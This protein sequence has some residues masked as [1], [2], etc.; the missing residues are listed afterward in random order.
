MPWR[1]EGKRILI[2]G[3]SAGIGRATALAL[4]ERGARVTLTSRDRARGADVAHALSQ[5]SGHR[6]ESLVLDLSDLRSIA[7]AATSFAGRT[8][9]LDVL[10]NNAGAFFA[11]LRN[12]AQGIEATMAVNHLGPF[13]LTGLLLP[14]LRS[15]AARR[16]EGEDITVNALHP[17][18][19]RTRLGSGGDASGPTGLGVRLFLAAGI[20]PKRGARASVELA[21]DATLSSTSGAYF[22]GGLLGTRRREP[23][24]TAG[25]E[26][27]SEKLWRDSMTVVTDT[28]GGNAPIDDLFH[29]PAERR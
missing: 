28:L 18:V 15:A 7:E 5:R 9:G 22:I 13:C 16:L 10:I 19:V 25:D 20:S 26:A 1:I 4:A 3:A 8:G 2:T 23:N 11:P 27:L 24:A 12:S 14:L 21:C 29:R 6:V 17:G